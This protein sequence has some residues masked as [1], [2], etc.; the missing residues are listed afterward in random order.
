[1]AVGGYENDGR[2]Q[3]S[4]DGL[5]WPGTS[6]SFSQMLN[7]V[8]WGNGSWVVVGDNGLILHAGPKQARLTRPRLVNGAFEMTITTEPGLSS[9]TILGST[10]LTEW[11]Q[12]QSVSFPPASY[13]FRDEPATATSLRFYRVY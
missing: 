10:N 9:Y 6:S 12:L 13:I 7:A 3:W 5:G 8:A 1:M 2:L 11:I 4:S